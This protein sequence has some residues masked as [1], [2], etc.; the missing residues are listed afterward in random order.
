MRLDVEDLIKQRPAKLES[1]RVRNEALYG[2][3][4]A[5]TLTGDTIDVVR[6]ITEAVVLPF[7]RTGST[8]PDVTSGIQEKIRRRMRKVVLFP[9]AWCPQRDSNPCRRLE[10]AV[11]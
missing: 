4:L 5:V 8:V 1:R 6:R 10:R 11:S 9:S 3:F 7:R 2:Q